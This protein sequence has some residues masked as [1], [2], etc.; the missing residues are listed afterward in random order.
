ML[1][2]L[3]LESSAHS[4]GELWLEHSRCLFLSMGSVIQGEVCTVLLWGLDTWLTASCDEI[5]CSWL[6]P[7]KVVLWGHR[8]AS[9]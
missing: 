3:T 6:I 8:V 4:W 1:L 5:A 9:C 7:C 2:R